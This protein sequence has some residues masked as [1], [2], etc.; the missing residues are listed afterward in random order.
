MAINNP[1][2]PGF[3]NNTFQPYPQSYVNINA[4]QPNYY[5]PPMSNGNGIYTKFVSS[6]QEAFSSIPVPQSGCAFGVDGEHM[7]FYAK[8]ADG[9]PMEVYDMVL[10]EPPKA[11]QPI[12]T[13]ALSELLDQKFND[14][15][16]ALSKKFVLRKD[17][18]N[19]GGNLNG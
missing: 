11:P 8:Y 13:D 16:S 7:V 1:N 10:R 2:Q 4:A 5:Q 9:R 19:R 14:F 15:E 17:N 18:Q 3:Q 12:T 6:E